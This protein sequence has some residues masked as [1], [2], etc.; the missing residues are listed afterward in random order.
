MKKSKNIFLIVLGLVF[1]VSL[2]NAQFNPRLQWSV[3]DQDLLDEI[4][5]EASGETAFN[6]VI[7]MGAYNRNRTAKE[8]QTTFWE[9]EYV[10]NKMKEYGLKGAEIVR[11]PGGSYWD[12]IKGEL[13][14]VSPGKD[15]KSVV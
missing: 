9:S 10:Y 15:R 11:Y 3:L 14:E 12:G 5:G 1:F 7:E 4:I 6:H 2:S 13:W 8:F